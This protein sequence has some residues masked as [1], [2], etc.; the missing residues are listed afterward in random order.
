MKILLIV[1]AIL[2]L[3]GGIGLVYGSVTYVKDRDTADFGPF[4][5]SFEQKE[6]VQIHPALGAVLLVA[7]VAVTAAGVRK[8]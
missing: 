3:L 6:T 7:G 8:R 1:G 4:D 5:V 2:M